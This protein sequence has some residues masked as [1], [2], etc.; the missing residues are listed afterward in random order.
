[1]DSIDL[2]IGNI[3]KLHTKAKLQDRDLYS[4]LK[5]EL[6]NITPEERFKYLSAIL[7]DYFEEYQFDEKDE[8]KADGYIIKR[9]Y[10]KRED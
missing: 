3:L 4:F 8:F 10:P 1:L 2:S 9:F 6:P 5:E 7:N